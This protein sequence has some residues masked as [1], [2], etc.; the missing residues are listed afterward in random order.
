M[1]TADT[2]TVIRARGRRL[3]KL[4]RADGTVE[5]YDDAKHFDLFAVPVPNLEALH[6]LLCRLLNRSAC[7]V[8]R[9][10]IAG[11][12]RVRRVRR[13]LHPDK[14]TGEQP[15]LREVPHYWLALDMEGVERPEGLPA[16]DNDAIGPLPPA[17][18]DDELA[19]AFSARHDGQ[20]LYVLG[21]LAA[22][23]WL[24]MGT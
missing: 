3:A 13:L 12:E 23:G 14:K 16:A 19:Q 4:I 9:G 11:P 21:T 15:T 24:P 17:F 5:G 2:L 18:S 8:V 6:R 10:A 22:L 20:L 7:A 1:T